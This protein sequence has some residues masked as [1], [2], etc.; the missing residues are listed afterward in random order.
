[1]EMQG[2]ITHK[3]IRMKSYLKF[4][5]RNK[6]YTAIEAVGLAVSLAF[7]ILIG[8]YAWQQWAVTREHPDRENIYNF[9]IPGY[10]GLTYGFTDAVMQQVPEAQ[11]AVRYANNIGITVQL[12]DKEIHSDEVAAVGKAFFTMF[13]YYR[14]VEGGSELFDDVNNVL[15]SESFARTHGLEMGQILRH[16]DNNY[17]VAGILEDLKGTLFKNSEIWFNEDNDSINSWAK[18]DPYDHYGSAIVF[19]K[20]APG[21]D[22]DD[23]YDKVEQVCKNI[24]GEWYGHGFFEKLDMTRM[25]K[26]FFKKFDSSPFRQGDMDTLRI[27]AIV[28]LLLLFSAIFNYINLSFA[29]TGKR[30]KEMAMRRLV[31][32]NKGA[33]I[34][35]YIVESIVFTAVCFGL[36][37]LLAYAFAPTV[38]SLLNDPDVPISVHFT[39]GYLL[40][41]LLLIALVGTLAGLL[42]ALLAGRYKPI[43]IVRGT[44]RRS[45]RM[46]IS[47]VFIIL[48]NALAVFLIAMA[49]IMEA[50]YRISQNRPMHADIKNLVLIR[51]FAEGNEDA[52]EAALLKLP[53]VQELGH[54]NNAPLFA[55]NGQYSTTRDGRDI[56]YWYH[57]VD[58]TAFRMLGYEVLKDY[59]TP[60]TGGVWFCE[61]AFTKTGLSDDD[62][63]IDVLSYRT[64]GDCDHVAGV[65]S[66]FP[67]NASNV[68]EI[69]P[70]IVTIVPAE[71]LEGNILLKVSGEKSEVR[72]ALQEAVD[73]WKETTRVYIMSFDFVEDELLEGLRPARNNMRLLEIFMLLAVIISLLGLVAMSTYYAGERASSIALRKVFG[74]TVDSELWRGVRD[75]M[76]MVGIACAIGISVAVWTAGKYLERF[77]VKLENYGWVFVVA[78]VVSVVFAFASVLWQTLKAAKT[79]PA[80]ELKKE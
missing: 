27:L 30:A 65:I 72:K 53:C 43:D 50:Q 80:I 49:L 59:H 20:F 46:T 7:V 40:V 34:G 8:S 10:P 58:T 73:R 48:Q 24:Y 32:A 69:D 64:G 77:T 39:P 9:G 26:L 57:R 76:V 22:P 25:D 1:M 78:M 56:M 44:F 68:G 4:L 6:L 60:L 75:Y 3:L 19:V 16:G 67:V 79:N 37:L 70:V 35:K 36:G 12:G 23:I 63:A 38:N 13:P 33:I 28:G 14:F 71:R 61:T 41:Y 54:A 55:S 11:M 62:L 29:L 51:A 21:T 18:S 42:P 15:V 52:L 5:S 31:G 74:G 45:T 47:K 17:T 66:D 2:H